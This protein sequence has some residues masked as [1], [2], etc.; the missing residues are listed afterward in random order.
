[1]SDEGR[2]RFR[3]VAS[4]DGLMLRHVLPRRLRGLTAQA[5]SDL[6]K[7]G[8]VLLGNVRVRV[9]T[10][11][12]AAGERVTVF[13][14]AAAARP[15]DPDDL[16][17]VRQGA[18]FVIV[19]KPAGVPVSAG[20]AARGT[21]A[22]ALVARLARGG[23]QRP[24][25][26]AVQAPPACAAGLCLFTVRGQHTQSFHR[27]FADAPIAWRA[28]ARLA[29]EV[30]L[31]LVCDLAVVTSPSGHVRVASTDH[32]GGGPTPAR[33]H[34]R[35]LAVD[36]DGEHATSHVEVTWSGGPAGQVLAH[37]AALGHP[38]LPLAL[39]SEGAEPLAGDPYRDGDADE[40]GGAHLHVLGLS[41]THPRTGD[42]LD[43]TVDPPPWARGD[44]EA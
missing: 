40:F 25:V 30:P 33:T 15:L 2:V 28:R 38:V 19:D 16:Q 35:R 44:D 8:G 39:P 43:V 29:G 13:P 3:V 4:E 9:P 20:E 36:G 31:E 6:V 18:D 42:R 37:A 21:L 10:V 32:R 24:Y 5:A 22:A 27:L 14:A 11:R 26:G 23:L 41:F 7:A 34:L 17:I 12:V 1:M